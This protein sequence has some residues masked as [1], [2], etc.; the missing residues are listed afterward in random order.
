MNFMEEHDVGIFCYISNV[1]DFC[2]VLKQR[3]AHTPGKKLFLAKYHYHLLNW[4]CDIG[5]SHLLYM[6]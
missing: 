4:V 2:E 1:S 6:K 3:L 5:V